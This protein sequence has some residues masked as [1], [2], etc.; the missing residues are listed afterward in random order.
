MAPRGP[1]WQHSI[2]NHSRFRGSCSP[3]CAGPSGLL[4]PKSLPAPRNAISTVATGWQRAHTEHISFQ[5]QPRVCGQH[6]PSD[7]SA[8]K[9]EAGA[10][11]L[12]ELM[13]EEAAPATNLLHSRGAPPSTS[14]GL[15]G[16][17]PTS[18]KQSHSQLLVTPGQACRSGDD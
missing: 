2:S 18:P 5:H 13:A 11:H 15:A 7:L 9:A 6:Q 4:V 3:P 1:C 10:G 8:Q 12:G 16:T 17:S 14:E